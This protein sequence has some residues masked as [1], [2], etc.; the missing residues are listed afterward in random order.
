MDL[1]ENRINFYQKE[2]FIEHFKMFRTSL[3]IQNG[4]ALDYGFESF[5]P[6]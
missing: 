4:G 6:L 5:K 1:L 2:D 3:V